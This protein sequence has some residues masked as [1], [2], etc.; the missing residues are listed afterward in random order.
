MENVLTLMLAFEIWGDDLIH[1][2]MKWNNPLFIC[3]KITLKRKKMTKY[4][5]KVYMTNGISLHFLSRYFYF[6]LN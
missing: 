3:Q 1:S 2:I 5:L 6:S 4:L